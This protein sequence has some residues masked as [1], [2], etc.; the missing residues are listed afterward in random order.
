MNELLEKFNEYRDISN[1][2]IKYTLAN[3]DVIDFKLKQTD[4]P[5]LIGLHKLVDIPLI[6][7]FNDVSNSTVSAK[8]LI[9]KIKKESQLTENIIKNSV[10]FPDIAQRYQNFSKENL[11]TLTYTDAIVDF[12]AS[13][14]SSK[15]R[16]DYILF[17]NQKSQGY[18][19]LSVAKDTQQ[20]RYAESFFYNPSDR[21][22][23][24]QKIVKV[25]KVE[26]YDTDGKLYLEDNI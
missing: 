25:S 6:G 10:Y 15:L 5:H 26:I 13:L 16:G 4:F 18:N 9:S 11:L 19:Y 2:R 21:Y 1:Y 22:I 14:I 24:N 8:F 20:K 3:E 23:R 17:E 7:Q 12:D